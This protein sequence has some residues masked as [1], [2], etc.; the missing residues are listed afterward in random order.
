MDPIL[1]FEGLINA[2]I[3]FKTHVAETLLK[4]L[5]SESDELGVFY[6][7]GYE[8]CSVTGSNGAALNP[9]G[10]LHQISWFTYAVTLLSL[11]V[12]YTCMWVPFI[13]DGVRMVFTRLITAQRFL[14]DGARQNEVQITSTTSWKSTTRCHEFVSQ[15]EVLFGPP[16]R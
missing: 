1:I 2:A 16:G 11:L 13:S 4:K 3:H 14:L 15:D 9:I 5:Q 10:M 6:I 12:I 7:A 8:F